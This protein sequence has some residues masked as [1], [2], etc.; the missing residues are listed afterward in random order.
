MDM[1]DIRRARDRLLEWTDRWMVQD[2]SHAP[3]DK[4]ERRQALR[5][6]PGTVQG[7]PG[8]EDLDRLMELVPEYR[9]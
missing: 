6:F 1:D 2:N 9:P 8:Q 4:L 3:A 5:D 7:E